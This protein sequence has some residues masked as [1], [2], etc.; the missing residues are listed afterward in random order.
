MNKLQIK[1]WLFS[2]NIENYVINDDLS[3][4][5]D[6]NV[7]ISY[8]QLTKIPVKFGSVSGRFS[9]YSNNLSSLEHCPSFVGG[10]FSCHN[11]MLTSLEHCPS[12]VG[13]NFYCYHN[14][15]TTLEHCPSFV[16]GHFDCDHNNLTSLEHH[17]TFVGGFYAGDIKVKCSPDVSKWLITKHEDLFFIIDNPSPDMIILYQMLW[18]I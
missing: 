16:G 9:C 7:N 17:P 8:R 14:N 1:D 3:V 10:N 11:N 4:D 2:M 18:E 6:G 15:L 12:F 5:V 13:G